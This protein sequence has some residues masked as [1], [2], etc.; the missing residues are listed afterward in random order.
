MTA[1]ANADKDIRLGEATFVLAGGMESMTNAPYL[2]PAARWGARMGDTKMLDSM[3]QDGLWCAF[4]NCSM[5]E[6]SDHKNTA[7][8][9]TREEQDEWSAQSHAR[10]AAAT[11][12]GHFAKEI[13]PVAVPQ[14]KG[15]PVEISADEGI[16]EGATAES[17]GRLRP[18]FTKDGTVTAGNASQISDGGA[19]VVVADR[20]AA[21]AAG[22]PILAEILG[23]G[24]MAGPTRRLH[25]RPAQALSIALEAGWSHRCRSR[26][27]GVQRG[28][29]G[30]RHLVD[31]DARLPGDK[32]NVHGGAV[33]L[34]HPWEPP[35]PA[36][37]SP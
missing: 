31:E 25:E 18:A 15:D 13:V 11:A 3:M 24:Q 9:V 28:V 4:D 12:S 8:G 27:G 17:L 2:M 6:S 10:A 1:I 34:G 19:A 21:E 7:L 16:R 37:S 20:A 35:E 22:M 30:R 14:R 26:S 32:V 23:Y 29:C 33:A 5:G 36:S